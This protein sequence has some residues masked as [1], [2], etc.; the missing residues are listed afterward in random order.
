MKNSGVKQLI[1][2][3]LEA[4][5]GRKSQRRQSAIFCA[6]ICRS[7]SYSPLQSLEASEDAQ[8]SPFPHAEADDGR[9]SSWRSSL[10]WRSSGLRQRL[11]P[12]IQIA[13]GWSDLAFL[14]HMMTGDN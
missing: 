8:L 13:P 6:S 10:P 7:S 3:Q 11:D 2:S 5:T 1:E 12:G 4:K 9:S 14:V